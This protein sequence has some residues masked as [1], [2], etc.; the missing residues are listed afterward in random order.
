MIYTKGPWSENGPTMQAPNTL[1]ILGPEKDDGWQTVLATINI[2][3]S[4]EAHANA[5]LMAHAAEMYEALQ[6]IA[7]GT[8][9][10]CIGLAR[11][12]VAKIQ[13]GFVSYR[14]EL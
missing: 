13:G 12:L 2:R 10:S 4:R 14:I 8:A 1:R 6:R 11:A 3:S 7:D 9:P 5:R